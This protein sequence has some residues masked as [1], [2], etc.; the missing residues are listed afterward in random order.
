MPYFLTIR[1]YNLKHSDSLL[2]R[3]LVIIDE[4]QELFERNE[5][6][7]QYAI[8]VMSELFKKGRA[9]GISLLW[10]SQNVP[11]VA[12]LRDK[13]ISQIGNR[14]S[15][16]LNNSDDAADLDIDPK[17]VKNL[18]RPEKGLVFIRIVAFL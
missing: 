11:K 16:R 7:G 15:L 13:V 10:A 5:S 14:I 4:V 6:L 1:Q 18:N 8:N 12:G 17:K 9:F 2:P 3:M